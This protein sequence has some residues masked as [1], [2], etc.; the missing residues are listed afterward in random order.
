M[1]K[2]TANV[3]GVFALK[4]DKVIKQVLFP[5]DPKEIAEKLSLMED[6]ICPEEEQIIKELSRTGVNEVY[7][8]NPD[9][10]LGKG[11]GVGFLPD[12]GYTDP[13]QMAREI[14]VTEKEVSDL[15]F[16][17]NLELTKKKLRILERDQIMIQAV[18][19]LDDIEEVSNRLMERLR[20]WY[21]LH[22]PELDGLVRN[23]DLYAR[24]VADP[25]TS[26]DG[27]LA[28]DIEEAKKESVGME[29]SE[30]DL[31]AVKRLAEAVVKLDSFRSETE[32][33]I[34]ELMKEIAPNTCELA[35]PLLGARLISLAGSLERLS[36]LPASTIQILGAEQSFFR[37]LKTRKMP[38]KHGVIF[39][40]PEIRSAPKHLR[41]KFSRKF[42]AKLA[43]CTKADYFKGE[44]IGGAIRKNFLASVE[45]MKMQPVKQHA[46]H[47][48]E[49]GEVR[50]RG[51]GKKGFGS[52]R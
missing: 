47:P 10:F 5:Q 9:R 21:S 40:L 51:R 45:E 17:A 46:Q 48:P 18:S 15:I 11:L 44:F 6:G 19:S 37:F 27:S 43:I 52:K 2:I 31:A 7:V 22:A 4:N 26:V 33:Y 13:L 29:F 49:R 16:R 25:K 42:A 24:L 39:Q 14:G 12:L 30:S 20:E 38:P 8:Q 3:M 34:G 28:R 41:G 32:K 23:N 50:Y 35:G 36:K 1:I